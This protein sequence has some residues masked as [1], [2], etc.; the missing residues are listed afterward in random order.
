MLLAQA[1]F[2]LSSGRFKNRF[3]LENHVGVGD[4]LLNSMHRICRES[5]VAERSTITERKYGGHSL[6]AC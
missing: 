2:Q 5:L 1:V 3:D 6:Y 4:E